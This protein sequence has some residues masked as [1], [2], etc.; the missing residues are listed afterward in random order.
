M[1]KAAIAG[2]LL[3]AVL[4]LS[5]CGGQAIPN[6]LGSVTGSSANVQDAAQVKGGSNEIPPEVPPA[7]PQDH[8]FAPY[9]DPKTGSFY[10]VYAP[11]AENGGYLGETDAIDAID[12]YFRLPD[13]QKTGTRHTAKNVLGEFDCSM[14]M[15]SGTNRAGYE[16]LQT[17]SG[18]AVVAT[19][20]AG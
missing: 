15:I 7:G 13:S 1:R 14:V 10:E 19:P 16:C 18:L 3:T 20:Q 8:K 6:A 11:V 5:A 12:A 4:S 9:Q 17:G 2:G